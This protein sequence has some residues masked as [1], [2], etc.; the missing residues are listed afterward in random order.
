MRNLNALETSKDFYENRYKKGY[1]EKWPE[2][3][4]DR[5]YG[6]IRSLNLPHEGEGLDFGCGNGVFTEMLKK[7]LPNWNI[8]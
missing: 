1:M 6:V 3:K 4:K 2:D 8:Y 7:A 5:V